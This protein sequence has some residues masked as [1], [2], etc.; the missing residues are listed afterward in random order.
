MN[1]VVL[2]ERKGTL[3]PESI[4]RAL[5][6]VQQ[7]HAL[8]QTHISWTETNG[9]RFEPAP[10]HMIDLACHKVRGQH[11]QRL[12]EQELSHTFAPD[13][14]PLMRCIYIEW[15]ESKTPA[16]DSKN[17]VLALTF[18]HSVADGRSGT[19]ILRRLL[20][21]MVQESAPSSGTGPTHLPPM[22]ELMPAPYRWAEQPDAAKQLRNTLV[23]DY[24]RHGLLPAIP[25]L[26]AEANSR[27]PR[28]IRLQLDAPS[29]T[30]LIEQARAQG[31]TVHGA[32]CAAQLLAQWQQQPT[33]EPVASFLCCPVDLR[34]HLDPVP[35]TSPTGF[36]TSLI[37]GSFLTGPDTDAWELA[38]EIVAQTR[39]QIAR[40]EGHLLYH[41][42][43]L[44]GS[45]LPPQVM[46]VFRKKALAS[47]PNTMVSNIGVV[48]AVE[49]DPAVKAISFALCPMPYQTLFTAAS[50]YQGRLILNLGYDA[51]RITP[52]TAQ[53]LATALHDIL[54]LMSKKPPKPS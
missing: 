18:H 16:S 35:A 34:P 31:S 37:S 51:A 27:E 33:A 44:D 41:L 54:L 5:H 2:A 53:A 1:F 15:D 3:A 19:A 26:A 32:L 14:A 23:T 20:S 10:G 12:I 43:G 7:E 39:Q 9:L 42:Y 48:E 52:K 50:C 24:R 30:R 49:D 6:T 4:R 36:F 38:R 13:S 17:C 29:T 46:D 8:L 40:G 45:P 47:L 11:W 28:L 25:W 21:L 22:A